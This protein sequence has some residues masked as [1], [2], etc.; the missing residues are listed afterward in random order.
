M[1]QGADELTMLR[2]DQRRGVTRTMRQM[3]HSFCAIEPIIIGHMMTDGRLLCDP[4]KGAF[5]N[6]LHALRWASGHNIRLLPRRL[7]L[8]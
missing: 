6:T 4:L 3:I 2:A 1:A 8:L 5:G 7:Q